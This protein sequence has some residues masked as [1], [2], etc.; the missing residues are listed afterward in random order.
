MVPA[1]PLLLR[2]SG[3][4]GGLRAT[5]HGLPLP[6]QNKG[7]MTALF[8]YYDLS[9]PEEGVSSGFKYRTIPHVTLKSVANNPEIREGMTQAELDDVTAKYAEQEVLYDQPE[10]DTGKVRV[11]GPFTLEAVPAPVVRPV[12][13]VVIGQKAVSLD[14]QTALPGMEQLDGQAQLGVHRGC[15]DCSLR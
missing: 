15:L 9:R 12:S 7:L 14:D 6:W 8:D 10:I 4:D 2:S 3:G 5:L 1:R 11:T 13:E